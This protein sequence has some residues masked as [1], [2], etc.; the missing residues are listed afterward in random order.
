MSNEV[1]LPAIP[2]TTSNMILE[3]TNSL[4]VPREVLP[5]DDEVTL[6]W[7]GLPRQLKNVPHRYR[8][9]LLARMCVAIH[10]G[11]FDSAL[12]YI[13]N[14]GVTAL[15]EKVKHFGL[16]AVSQ[17]VGSRFDED[18]LLD[19]RDAELLEL[20]LKLNLVTEDGSVFLQIS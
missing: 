2:V 16:H 3:L 6:A 5:S 1:K 18:A 7:Y 10:V 4:N 9:E 17:V 19:L 15:R 14:I 12:N 8:S 20:C 11:L 13:W